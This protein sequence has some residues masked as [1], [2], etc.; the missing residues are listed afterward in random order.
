MAVVLGNVIRVVTVGGERIEEG[1]IT[2]W[3]T[4]AAKGHSKADGRR[5]RVL[6]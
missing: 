1:G 4:G 5:R 2:E 3:H 6:R